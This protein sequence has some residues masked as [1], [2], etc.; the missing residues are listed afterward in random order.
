M[1]KIM[2]AQYVELDLIWQKVKEDTEEH[3]AAEFKQGIQQNQLELLAAIRKLVGSKTR[4][5]VGRAVR[6]ARKERLPV[7][8]NM[9]P[10]NATEQTHVNPK[11]APAG[12]TTGEKTSTSPAEISVVKPEPAP[13]PAPAPAPAPVVA[14]GTEGFPSNRKIVHEMALDG[15]FRLKEHKPSGL[16]AMI[17]ETMKR[18]FFDKMKEDIENGDLVAWVP[19]M[20]TTVKEKLLKLVDPKS[21]FHKLIQ[22]ALDIELIESQCRAG[23]YDHEKFFAFILWLLPKLCSPARD[24]EVKALGT[25]DLSFYDRLRRLLDLLEAMQLDYANYLL[26]ASVRAIVPQAIPYERKHFTDDLQ[27]GRITL[28]VTRRWLESSAKEVLAESSRRT[29]PNASGKHGLPSM[30]SIYNNAYIDLAFAFDPLDPKEIPETFHLDHERLHGIRETVRTLSLSSAILTTVKSLMRRDARTPWTSLKEKINALLAKHSPSDDSST[31]ATDL[32]QFIQETN[33]IPPATQQHIASAVTRILRT[34]TAPSGQLDAVV[35]VVFNRLKQFT[36][37]RL[38]AVSQ[39]D[40]VQLATEAPN[41]LA[42]LGLVE[43]VDDVARLV[44]KIDRLGQ[45]NRATYEEWYNEIIK[46]AI[47]TA[48]KE[49]GNETGGPDGN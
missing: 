48:G 16:E 23:V 39:K 21:A 47:E 33:A 49:N 12:P 27:A 37:A 6:K 24:D 43:Q 20:A 36:R 28:T 2:I 30:L 14:A 8:K 35:R 44:E 25:D 26:M 1:L 10:R 34:L 15:E 46:E 7:K 29:S 31:F 4:E 45:L 41:A 22:E 40:R 42:S 5:L 19:Q 18:A 9:T 17:A 11:E 32:C 3:A 38:E 13:T